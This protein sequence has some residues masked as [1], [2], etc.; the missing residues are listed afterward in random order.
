MRNLRSRNGR[1]SARQVVPKA[2]VPVVGKTE[3]L[4]D[5]GTDR[6]KALERHPAALAHLKA[7]IKNDRRKVDL[8][9]GR[10]AARRLE[11]CSPEEIYASNYFE[12]LQQDEDA[13]NSHPAYARIS[14]DDLFV[15]GLPRGISGAATDT[16]LA[17]LVGHRISYY[18]SLGYTAAEFGTQGW[19][20]L[21]RMLCQSEYEALERVAKRDEGDVSGRSNNPILA[22]PD[23]REEEAVSILGLF[24][25]YI[26]HRSMHQD[27]RE[28][29]KRWTP[30]FKDLV[31]S[32]RLKS[33]S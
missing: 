19:R 14:I 26:R 20:Q 30:V 5:L 11:L 28:V 25:G 22:I 6:R 32:T 2:L 10:P 16:E 9:S 4:I 12:R 23:S 13:R 33:Q 31:A 15:S 7:Q 24:D 27:S 3:L 8:D 29:Q 18:Q 17:D 1:Y 21:A